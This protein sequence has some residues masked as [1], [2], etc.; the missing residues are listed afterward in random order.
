M[1]TL[2]LPV[3]DF[4]NTLLIFQTRADAGQ[5]EF[6]LYQLRIALDGSDESHLIDILRRTANTVQLKVGPLPGPRILNFIDAYYP[7]W[8]A[9]ING[10]S[11]PIIRSND[12]FKAVVVPAGTH[13]VAFEFRP[14]RVFW[15]LAISLNTIALI[16]IVLTLLAVFNPTVSS[17]DATRPRDP[18]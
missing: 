5:P 13:I 2:E 9:T 15:G 1:S 10:K 18:L 7:G 6:R 12:A 4:T 11:V 16:G 17:G 3:P 8:G 14:R